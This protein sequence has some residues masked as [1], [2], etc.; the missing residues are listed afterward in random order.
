MVTV[1]GGGLMSAQDDPGPVPSPGL[2]SVGELAAAL[3][4]LPDPVYIMRAVRDPDGMVV[5]LRYVFL[6]E[7][8]ARLLARPV[9]PLVGR[10][11]SEVFP[12]VRELGI[13]DRYV[14]VLDSAS[15]VVFDVPWFRENGVDGSF[16][17][18][19]T[20]FEDGLLVSA[21]DI[22]D[23]IRARQEAE[24]DRAALR[25]T[26][27]SLLDP[28]VRLDSVRDDS[29]QIVDFVYVDANPAACAYNRLD[30]QDLVGARLLDLQAG[31]TG[32]GLLD[33]YAHVVETGEPLVLDDIVYAQELRGGQERHYDVRAMRVGDGLSYTWRDVTERHAAGRWLAESE[34]QYRFL[35]ENASDV[36][37][38]LSPDRRFEWVSGSIGDVLGWA[39]T[40]LLGHVIDEFIHPEGLALFRQA[41]AATGPESAASMDFRFRRSDGGYR[42]V[43][44]RT[45]LKLDEDGTPVALVGG[46]VDID[47]RK[48]VEAQDLDRLEEL[49]RFQRLTV[50]RELKMIELKQEIESLRRLV[51]KDKSEDGDKNKTD[52]R[53]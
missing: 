2:A 26:A 1:L 39:T 7:A 38:R 18:T 23:L 8:S 46:L 40:D 43:A 28:H 35:A 11:L 6:N 15:P 17:L 19:A 16:R 21:S 22:T 20:R 29:G 32:T 12:S 31:S 25:A 10:G 45:R 13:F 52:Q 41:V 14:A 9:E 49:Q 42:W 53:S 30:Y 4:A 3:S 36:V 47:A 50:G 44:C 5:E 24:A 34:E 51:Q 37:M 33:Q 48:V 27:D